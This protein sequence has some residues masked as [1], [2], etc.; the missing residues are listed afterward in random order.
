MEVKLFEIRDRATFLPAMAI[1]LCSRT[2]SERYLLSRAGYGSTNQSHGE[3][4]LMAQIDGGR[5]EIS[6]DT[7]SWGK[8]PRTYHVAHTHIKENWDNLCSGDV[9]DVEF[10]LGETQTCKTSE[11][12]LERY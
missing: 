9:I 12:L 8:N 7:Y 4:I 11:R 3:Y 10:V 1:R 5:G 6:S 2:E